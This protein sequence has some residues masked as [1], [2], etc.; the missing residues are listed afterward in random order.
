[1]GTHG[2]QL[3][4]ADVLAR[5]LGDQ[6]RLARIASFMVIQCLS[7]G[8]YDEAVRFGQE[9]LS[10][11][12]TLGDRS[13]EMV[14]TSFLG[15]THAVKGEFSAAA[16]LL[17][18]NAALEDDLRG[19]RFG[20]AAIQSAYSGAHLV[21]VLARL[22]R[23]DEA[24]GQAE[25]T[26][27]SAEAA[28]HAFTLHQGLSALGRA[29]LRRGDLPRATRVL[30]RGLELCRTWE[31][32]VGKPI[33]VA[34]LGAAY[35][36]AGRADEA[37]P[38]VAGAAEAFRGRQFHRWPALHPAMRG[39]DLPRG[40]ADRRGRLE[41]LPHRALAGT[42]HA[43][44]GVLTQ[45]LRQIPH[46]P[47]RLAQ[48]AHFRRRL[49][50]QHQNPGLPICAVLAWRWAMRAVLQAGQPGDGKPVAPLLRGVPRDPQLLGNVDV[51]RALRSPQHDPRA[52]RRLLTARS[53]TRPTL[54]LAPLLN[55]HMILVARRLTRPS[56]SACLQASEEA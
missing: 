7:T 12:R 43:Q 26:V 27:Q 8:D 23:F 16:T 25:A 15:T 35:A 14:A 20:A 31:I 46:R 2:D 5:T 55:R 9:A 54:Q 28:D 1:M 11:G 47:V 21:D 49:A 32:V 18:R 19:E 30:E 37:L 39:D 34:S 42:P 4:E 17:E 53:R 45:I 10:I 40:G 52:L 3:H 41:D 13:I 38:L 44:L 56:P 36:L 6:Q 33:V 29:H 22:G 24:I 50:G 51:A 48:P